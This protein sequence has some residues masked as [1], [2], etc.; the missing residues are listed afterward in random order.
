MILILLRAALCAQG[1]AW[2]ASP[3][4]V[5]PYRDESDTTDA[6]EIIFSNLTP[7]AGDLYNDDKNVA[8]TIA[9]VSAPGKDEEWFA[10]EFTPKFDVQA[11]VLEAAIGYTSGTRRV[12]LGL[13][14]N[15][16]F[17][18]SVGRP[19]QNG[20]GS[21]SQIPNLG[22]CCQ[23]ARVTLPGQGANLK[24]K[25]HYWLVGSTDDQ[26]APTFLGGWH[27]SNVAQTEYSLAGAPW[28]TDAGAWPAAQIRGTRLESSD[29]SEPANHTVIT[30][31][32]SPPLVGSIIFTNLGPNPSKLYINGG[33]FYVAGNKAADVSEL[34]EALPFN[35]T[36]AVHAKTLA[37][38]IGYIS[39]TKKVNLGIYSDDAGSVGTLLPG[40]QGSTTDIPDWDVCCGLAQVTLPGAGV[41]LGPG[42]YWL[43]ASPDDVTAPDF[44]GLW[45]MSSLAFDAVRYPENLGNW[46]TLSS[47][48]LA[49]EITGTNP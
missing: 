29:S 2:T 1:S 28:A 12:K 43:V 39:G 25:K 23:L 47:L 4:T 11:K 14:N 37:A 32:M 41:S 8:L 15:D 27:L 30:H 24:G 48:W 46:Y 5:V 9:G 6:S 21:T 42:R 33:G 49:A 35:V 45:Q 17:T 10:V 3:D 44:E 18:Q 26:N 22:S 16:R 38:A 20:E 34:W 13:Y 31:A 7:S 36:A 19:V 40:G